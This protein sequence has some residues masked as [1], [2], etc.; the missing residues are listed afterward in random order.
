[1]IAGILCPPSPS[2]LTKESPM[3]TRNV[4]IPAKASFKIGQVAKLLE[5]EPYVLRY[6]ETEFDQ[7]APAKTRAGQRAYT[8]ADVQ[9][10]LR[11]THL[12]YVDQYTI[13]GARRQLDLGASA[14]VLPAEHAQDQPA[15]DPSQEEALTRLRARCAQ[16]EGELQS[17]TSTLDI[18]HGQVATLQAQVARNDGVIAALQAEREELQALVVEATNTLEA[19]NKKIMAMEATHAVAKPTPAWELEH[20]TLCA[21]KARLEHDLHLAYQRVDDLCRDRTALEANCDE[22]NAKLRAHTRAQ[23]RVFAQLR[24]EVLQM[25]SVAAH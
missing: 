6:W 19:R 22:L 23:G 10:L 17:A 18:H 13:A 4:E 5:L 12:L 14:A 2:H 7:L 21:E 3:T 9:L 15:P 11:I 25:K 16:L 20:Q 8:Q 24:R 1:M